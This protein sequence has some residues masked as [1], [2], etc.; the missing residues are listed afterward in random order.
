MTDSIITFINYLR[1]KDLVE[2]VDFL[3]KASEFMYQK[4]I[5]LEAEEVIGAGRYERTPKRQTYRNGTRERQ[6]ETRVG[7]IT[8]KIPK[9][10][11]G[12]YFPSI[13]E[14]RKRSEEA[15]LAVIQEAYILGVS[16]RRMD[17]LVQRMGL[18]GIDKSKVSRICKELDEMVDQFRERKLQTH[19]P[20]I[21]L[22]AIVLNVRENHRVVKLS[23]GIAVGVD[24]QGERHILG[25]DLGAGES[26]V[27]WL[28]FLRSLKQRGLE[29]SMLVIS[30]A[31]SG[32]KAA[33]A[34][35]FSGGT[36]Q[37][38]SVH[39]MRNVLAQVSHKDKK[40][41]ADAIK[42]IFDQPDQA[43]AKVFLKK[44]AELME[45]R[46]PKVSRMLLEAKE[47]ILA[48]KTFPSVHHR[49]IHSVNPLERLNREI[50]RR[51][52]LVGVFPNRASV[53]RLVGTLL[54]EIDE[55]WRGGR[56]YMA[57]EGMNKLLNPIL[58]DP[59]EQSFELVDELLELEAQNAI[60]TT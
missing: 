36:W 57:Q 45:S 26:E 23:L 35:A 18:E 32:L 41:V 8:V 24:E 49:S 9:L 50:R 58:E 25:L 34:Q 38:C 20:Y 27:F 10:R 48:Y 15:L 11:R 46:W 17:E 7:K 53:F 29:E 54:M 6:L 51:T 31:H 40:Q 39:F 37:R 42:L 28:E 52:R 47:D 44:L 14:P 56:R 55:D 19:Y 30:D 4:L 43:S 21:W 22:D 12:S 13:L 59:S 33:I 1:K 3:K 60:Y 5:D 16:T 2:D